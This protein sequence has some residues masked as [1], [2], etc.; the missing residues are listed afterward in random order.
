MHFKKKLFIIISL[1]YI[2]YT[3]VPLFADY[4]PIDASIIN[5]LTFLLI[6]FLYPRAFIN[7]TIFWLLLYGFVLFIYLVFNK[8]LTIGIGTVADSKKLI[9]E[10]AFILPSLSILSV[11]Y[12]LKDIKLIKIISTVALIF[13]VL[14]FLYLLPLLLTGKSSLRDAVSL[15]MYQNIKMPGIPSYTLLHAYLII[16][17]A[18]LYGIVT[19]KSIKRV[20]LLAV[21]ILLLYIIYNSQITTSLV[22]AFA[23]LVIGILYDN[24]NIKKTIFRISI[25]GTI[26]L[27]LFPT[28]IFLQVLDSLVETFEGTAA[29]SKMEDFR[30]IFITGNI[31]DSSNI[32]GRS[33]LHGI[34]L[35][36]FADNIFIGSYPVGG[37]SNLL[38]RLGGLG[39]LGFIP[40]LMI[41]VSQMKMNLS[42]IKCREEKMY[43]FMGLFASFTLLALKGL[44]GQEGWLFMM[45][46]LPGLIISMQTSKAVKL[47]KEVK[48]L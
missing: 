40:Y 22:V 13:I 7:K 47:P 41:L 9:I 29:E 6:F 36:A 24:A 33:S 16:L 32:T 20:L 23:L 4:V 1:V 39:L 17:S 21:L 37:H 28:G 8:P 10:L 30:T 35:K 43:Y 11:L 14:S 25:V 2:I 26:L 27:L 15:E 45:V 19:L 38:D 3:V 42:F 31:T 44:F 5:L 46:L 18:I 48:M 34:S 12:Y